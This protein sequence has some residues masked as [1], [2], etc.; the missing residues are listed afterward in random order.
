MPLLTDLWFE[1]D[2]DY[3]NPIC[4]SK[5]VYMS[6]L[7][8]HLAVGKVRVD[9][10]LLV[11]NAVEE[12][13]MNHSE[14]ILKKEANYMRDVIKKIEAESKEADRR[15]RAVCANKDDQLKEKQREVDE[16]KRQLEI[17]D[18]KQRAAQR[19]DRQTQT[20]IKKLSQEIIRLKESLTACEGRNES[21]TSAYNSIN[22]S[23]VSYQNQIAA[24]ES[25]S[26]ALHSQN[27]SLLTTIK[28]YESTMSDM[29]KMH[30]DKIAREMR[31]F[32]EYI[33]KANEERDAVK[34]V[35]PDWEAERLK[36]KESIEAKLRLE[37]R[38]RAEREVRSVLE[39]ELTDHFQSEFDSRLAQE[40]DKLEE[41]YKEVW[42]RRDAKAK[43]ENDLVDQEF[44]SILTKMTE[45]VKSYE[46]RVET[47]EKEKV[48]STHPASE[49]TA[50]PHAHKTA[51]RKGCCLDRHDSNCST[52]KE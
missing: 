39:K 24:L 25:R 52:S 11:G 32:D 27:A 5:P 3:S 46:Q 35:Q 19:D 29:H 2:D 50:P 43:E 16:L 20:T 48:G 28:D 4:T 7:S 34:A 38:S 44:R 14:D 13:I 51:A 18:N 21:L 33:K 22:A 37:E 26:I 36:I 45:K 8:K 42:V 40:I 49:T 41:T 9:G 31:R 1:D 6:Y 15:W 12:S 10:K 17:E 30:T 23:I 47:V